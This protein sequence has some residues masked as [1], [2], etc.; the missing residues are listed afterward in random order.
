MGAGAGNLMIAKQ[1]NEKKTK[2]LAKKTFTPSALASPS[3][4]LY[5][6]GA[7]NRPPGASL[8]PAERDANLKREYD[9]FLASVSKSGPQRQG[10]GL[11]TP[12]QRAASIL[13]NNRP[14][15]IASQFA[16]DLIEAQRK[17]DTTNRKERTRILN[18]SASGSRN[19]Y[20]RF[21]D[22]ATPGDVKAKLGRAGT[23]VRT[24]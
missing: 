8:S 21:G 17:L 24:L 14:S 15:S 12:G 2:E 13:E 23:G 9:A 19:L 10:F 18:E 16:T 7:A 5:S 6:T 1:Q 3:R 22:I 20:T 11:E 4:T